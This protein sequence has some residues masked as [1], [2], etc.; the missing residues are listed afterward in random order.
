MRSIGYPGFLLPAEPSST[1]RRLPTRCPQKRNPRCRGSTSI[2]KC[3]GTDMPAVIGFCAVDRAPIAKEQ[4]GICVSAVAE[5][6]D[7]ADASA[8]Q[9]CG[10]VAGK[11]KEGVAGTCGGPEETLVALRRGLEALD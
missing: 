9:S 1:A 3:D 2:N 8:S 7:P 10:D 5:V 6:L 11:I 4:V